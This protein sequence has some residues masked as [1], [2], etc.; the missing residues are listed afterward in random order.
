[1]NKKLFLITILACSYLYTADHGTSG[2]LYQKA[3]KAWVALIKTRPVT[4]NSIILHPREAIIFHKGSRFCNNRLI[5]YVYHFP[6]NLTPPTANLFALPQG[7]WYQIDLTDAAQVYQ[8]AWND[9]AQADKRW[10]HSA[11]K[12]TSPALLS[13]STTQKSAATHVPSSTAS[14]SK[15]EH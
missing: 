12:T 15:K 4:T 7:Q 10:F 9:Y 5:P 13:S 1:M 8:K 14:N 2:E 3:C 6:K 11:L